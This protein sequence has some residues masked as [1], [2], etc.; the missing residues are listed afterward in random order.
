MTTDAHRGGAGSPLVL[1]HGASPGV[2]H[3]PMWDDPELVVDA[4]LGVAL[5]AGR[6]SGEQAV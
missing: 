1:P 6:G 5:P 3:V 2:G 4:I